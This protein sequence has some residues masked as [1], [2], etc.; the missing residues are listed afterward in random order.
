MHWFD[1]FMNW[2]VITMIASAF[3]KLTGAYITVNILV[4]ITA[5]A[6]TLYENK[7]EK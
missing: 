1:F 7:G 2:F 6:F 3:Q 4:L 5:L